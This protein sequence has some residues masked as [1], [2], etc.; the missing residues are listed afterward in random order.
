MLGFESFA[1]E[2]IGEN[3]QAARLEPRKSV[4][5]GYAPVALP[6]GSGSKE[7]LLDTHLLHEWPLEHGGRM[8]G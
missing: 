1:R 4:E 8:R 7:E 6:V 3:C 5:S 2:S